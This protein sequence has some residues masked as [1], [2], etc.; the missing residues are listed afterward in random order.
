M[1][2]LVAALQGEMLAQSQHNVCAAAIGCYSEGEMCHG[3][4]KPDFLL[5][6]AVTG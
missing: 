3:Y 5:P 1:L 2:P 6:L 4:L